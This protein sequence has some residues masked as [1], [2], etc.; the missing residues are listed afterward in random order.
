MLLLLHFFIRLHQS[1]MFKVNE[2]GK[3]SNKGRLV[4][5]LNKFVL[6]NKTGIKRWRVAKQV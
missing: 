4:K 3:Q 6:N 2:P 1:I 5:Q